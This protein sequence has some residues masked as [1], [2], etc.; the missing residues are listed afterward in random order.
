MKALTVIISI[1]TLLAGAAHAEPIITECKYEIEQG[2]TPGYCFEIKNL[3]TGG[4]WVGAIL[5]GPTYNTWRCSP[6][7]NSGGNSTA[8]LAKCNQARQEYIQRKR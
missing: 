2:K 6:L 7:A 8:A 3:K 4:G 1:S 5:V